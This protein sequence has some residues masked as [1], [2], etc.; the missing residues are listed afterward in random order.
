MC[1]F[2]LSVEHP[3]S[4]LLGYESNASWLQI[5]SPYSNVQEPKLFL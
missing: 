2:E 1:E 3:S 4:V 5:K